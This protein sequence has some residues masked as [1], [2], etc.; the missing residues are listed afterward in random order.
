MA[1]AAGLKEGSKEGLKTHDAAGAA[2]VGREEKIRLSIIHLSGEEEEEEKG[3]NKRGRNEGMREGGGK[4][5]ERGRKSE[6]RQAQH[7]RSG[8]RREKDA[9]EGRKET[10][11]VP[12]GLLS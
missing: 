9:Q 1:G 10:R 6:K 5:R 2:D 4:E 8:S 7:T 11:K 12:E 3:T